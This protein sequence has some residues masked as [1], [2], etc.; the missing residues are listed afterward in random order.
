MEKTHQVLL[1]QLQ[2]KQE[3]MKRYVIIQTDVN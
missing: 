3:I 1:N 2:G